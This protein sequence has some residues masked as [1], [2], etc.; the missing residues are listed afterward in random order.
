M[1]LGSPLDTQ[2]PPYRV[3]VVGFGSIGKRHARSLK[4]TGR[5]EV[6]VCEPVS[7]LRSLASQ[8]LETDHS[9]ADLE[10]ALSLPWD[11][12]VVATPAP[13]HVPVAITLLRE[14]VATL[15]EKPLALDESGL[16]ELEEL[17]ASR[18]LATAV[19]YV[20][21][22]HPVLA[23]MRQ[24]LRERRF[25]APLTVSVMAGQNFPHHRP[26]F[27]E[28]YYARSATGGGAIQDALTHLTNAVEWLVGPID[29]LIADAANLVLEGVEVEDTV[30]MLARH[31]SV[32]ANYICNQH[33]FL[34]ETV[35]TVVC[36]K[37]VTRFEMERNRWMWLDE[38]DGDWNVVQHPRM[39]TDEWFT[40]QAHM[41]LD[42]LSG[43]ASSLCSLD[44]ARQSVRVNL[45][46]LQA[47][48]R[49]DGWRRVSEV[50]QA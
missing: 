7:E 48:A 36:E 24:A 31:G 11:C 25:G 33:Q 34:N 15:I 32:M 19:G 10:S 6:G 9:Y 41:F 37:G 4:A 13:S 17:A 1:G 18:G 50:S 5:A 27:R 14:G 26:G 45:A 21:R 35:V 42:C 12:A 20:Y 3:L 8:I 49:G 28:T 46:A 44:E 43:K 23:E 40:R 30:H 16:D 47:V 22:V 39:E 29:E 38:I 2:T